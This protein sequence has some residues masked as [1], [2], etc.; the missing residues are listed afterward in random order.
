MSPVSALPFVTRHDVKAL[1]GFQAVE[2]LHSPRQPMGV[3]AI[4]LLTPTSQ[5]AD[6]VIADFQFGRRTYK[7]AHLFFIDGKCRRCL[8]SL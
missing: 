4:Y 5:N 2:P 1:N 7:S 3:D 8:Y 6:R